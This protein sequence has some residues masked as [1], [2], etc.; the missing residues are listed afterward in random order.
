MIGDAAHL[1]SPFSGEDVN[2]ALAD[3]VGLCD[4]LTSGAGWGA[5]ARFEAAMAQRA[6]P[7]AQGAAGG[8]NSVFSPDGA[9]PALAHYRERVGL[10]REGVA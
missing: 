2:L 9:A 4:A 7:A 1:M 5:M 3:A 8:L 6:A 10:A